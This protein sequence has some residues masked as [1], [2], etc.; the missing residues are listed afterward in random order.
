MPNAPA[1][2]VDPRQAAMDAIVNQHR[3]ADLERETGVKFEP[4]AI[5]AA[6][7]ADPDA[8]PDDAAAEAARKALE[9]GDALSQTNTNPDNPD[10]ADQL[11]AQDAAAAAATEAQR[12]ANEKA[13][14]VEIPFDP[15]AKIKVKVNGEEREVTVSEVLRDYQKGVSADERMQRNAAEARR[16]E[17]ERKALEQEQA[18]LQRQTQGKQPASNDATV[19]DPG[20][21]K[22]FTSALFAGDEATATQAFN[23]AVSSAVQAARNDAKGRGDTTP[24]DPN[25]IAT[26]VRQQIEVDS[27]LK[28][29]R[30]DY[31]M[32]FS[33]PDIEGLAATKITR[34]RAGGMNP[35]DAIES[36]VGEMA[37]KFGW[38]KSAASGRPSAISD[39]RR[40]EKLERKESLEPPLQTPS[41]KSGTTEEP[42]TTVHDTIREMA[43][44]R[45]QVI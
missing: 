20:V 12:K 30:A 10:N 33:D 24:V 34:L 38:K 9:A 21:A 35:A 6:T 28:Q 11:A 36:A 41:V 42:Q 39:G 14:G 8:D 1:K 13:T 32:V 25:A 31:P 43:K 19:V 4:L 2:Y 17:E 23:E 26:Q 27:V 15:S 29:V 37:E 3:H 5:E 7:L 44:A 22:K 45:G 40:K 18:A 16:L